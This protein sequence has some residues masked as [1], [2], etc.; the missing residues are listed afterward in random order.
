MENPL[1]SGQD[2]IALSFLAVK[3][4][5][6]VFTIY[7]RLLGEYEESLP[8][9]RWL[10]SDTNAE[11]S[12]DD[13]AKRYAVSLEPID[14]YEKVSIRA[15]VNPQI[16][17]NILHTALARKVQTPQFQG[18]AEVSGKSFIREVGFILQTHEEDVEEVMWLRAFDLKSIGFFGFFCSF[19]LRVPS[20]AQISQKR[21]LELSLAQKDGRINQAFYLDQY[22]KIGN[23]LKSY[24]PS[25][26][27]LE[28]H[29]GTKVEIE[30]KLS[31]V[32][33][34]ALDTRTYLF[35]G[36]RDGKNQFFGLRDHAPF[37][38]ADKKSRLAFLFLPED[39]AKSQD[40]FRALRG[41]TYSTFPGMEKMFKTVIGKHNVTGVEVTSFKHDDL[42][43]VCKVLK[44]QYPNEQLLPIVIVPF[45]KNVSEEFTLDYYRAK[46]AF[47]SEGLASQFVDRTKRLG[48]RD[49]L[50]W[51]ISN[52]ALAIFAKMG[53]VPWKVKP[54]TENCLIIGI[55]QAHTF[56][57]NI[58]EKYIAYSILTDSSGVYES[59]KV[60]GNSTN[61]E[62]YLTSLRTNLKQVLLLHKE[63]N[64]KSF[65]LH[66]TFSLAYEEINAIKDLLD[67]LRYGE[68]VGCEFVVIKFNDHNNFFG[69]STVHNSRIPN[70][71]TVVPL[72]KREFLIWFSGLSIA[73][74]KAPKKPERPVHLKVLYPHELLDKNDF[75]RLFQDAINI[76]GGNWRGFNAKSIPISIEYAKLI[77]KYYAHFRQADLNEVD[78]DNLPPWFL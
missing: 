5:D 64:Y 59:I 18:K 52:I 75:Y 41:D 1:I 38:C 57:N 70:E 2:K 4:K 56:T 48:D 34:F 76:A 71:G 61:R 17:V 40:L 19:S 23:F 77:A 69:F 39:R 6:F 35:A 13:H 11:K 62:E 67:D 37:K 45:S 31:L 51:S 3:Q 30:S 47:L 74:S 42:R 63:N 66:V 24:H 20:K 25:I 28:L 36:K 58:I 73:D 65:V 12:P 53:G 54:S 43:H 29:D 44:Q 49:S 26:C 9:V 16:T 78:M 72:S 15:W 32:P 7:R 68:A 22:T 14:G 55:G 60:L 33:S 50:K 46:H 27:D 21:R 10:P 8:G